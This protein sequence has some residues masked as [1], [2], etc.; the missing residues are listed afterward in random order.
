MLLPILDGCSTL[1][2]EE[3]VRRFVL[4]MPEMLERWISRCASSHTQR[5]YRQDLFTFITFTRLRWP[6]DAAGL[7]AVTVGQVQAYRDSILARGAA[8]KTINRRLSSLSGFFKFL[9]E[10][11]AE[12]RLPIQIANPAEKEFVARDNADPVHERR[13]FSATKARQLFSLP[14]GETV[15]DYRDSR[16]VEMPAVFWRA[17]RHPAAPQRRGLPARRG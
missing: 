7:L 16:H 10:I 17:Y 3:K 2:V 1:R 9:R 11:A 13:H 5:A 12:M 6:D 4:N 14:A 15:L 8:P